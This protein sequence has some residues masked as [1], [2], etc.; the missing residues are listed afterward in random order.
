MHINGRRQGAY[1]CRCL[2]DR[3]GSCWNRATAERALT[4]ERIGNAIGNELVQF[5]PKV[6]QLLSQAQDGIDSTS[7]MEARLATLRRE[8][9]TLTAQR[10]RYVLAISAAEDVAIPQLTSNSRNA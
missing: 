5:V 8:V 1:R 6:E 4:H 7:D 2:K 3:Q 10:N 9:E